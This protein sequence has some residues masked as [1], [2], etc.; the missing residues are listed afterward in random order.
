MFESEAYKLIRNFYYYI[1]FIFYLFFDFWYL[2]FI[3][4]NFKFN[5][6]FI[7][8][9]PIYSIIRSVNKDFEKKK[10]LE[11]NANSNNFNLYSVGD[12][13]YK[14]SK[15]FEKKIG[16]DY[17]LHLGDL[18]YKDDKDISFKN[19]IENKKLILVPGCREM[20][21]YNH[22]KKWNRKIISKNF[23]LDYYSI[24]IKLLNYSIKIFIVHNYIIPGSKKYYDLINWLR[25]EINHSDEKFKIIASHCPPY[26][27]SKHG[28]DYI[29]QNIL[30]L[31]GVIGKFDLFI[32]GHDH[33]YQKFNIDNTNFI[34]N[35][36]GGKSKYTFYNNNINLIK[37]YNSMESILKLCF[38]EKKISISLVNL[39]N[40]IID[41]FEVM[42]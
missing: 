11:I 6:Y 12:T 32:S 28:P 31:S 1:N 17:L 23:D 29:L 9:N 13:R 42:K 3:S 27:I 21:G 36:L 5:Y 30:K 14:I 7:P 39:E 18:Y 34:V 24:R 37:K 2:L 15:L 38:N 33:C 20:I 26:S 35:G 4:F 10:K 22:N 40:K 16:N 25:N 41:Y 19:L 8:F